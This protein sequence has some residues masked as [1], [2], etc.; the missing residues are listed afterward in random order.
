MPFGTRDGHGVWMKPISY[1]Q[2]TGEIERLLCPGAPQGPVQ[3]H[4][5]LYITKEKP[6]F[7]KILTDAIYIIKCN[8][9]EVSCSRELLINGLVYLILENVFSHR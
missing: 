9:Y 5:V 4:E 7:H 3:F 6:N 2:E 1:K 8:E